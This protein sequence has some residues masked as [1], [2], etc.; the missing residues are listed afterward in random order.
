MHEKEFVESSAAVVKRVCRVCVEVAP[1]R[2]P[3]TV[4][5]PCGRAIRWWQALQSLEKRRKKAIGEPCAGS[6]ALPS[7]KIGAGQGGAEHRPPPAL[8]KS[9]SPLRRFNAPPWQSHPSPHHS[10]GDV[11]AVFTA[12]AA[13]GRPQTLGCCPRLGQ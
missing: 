13:R 4:D 1:Q 10:R 5:Q 2:A 9:G 3:S 6:C 11:A 7:L 12:P 8:Q